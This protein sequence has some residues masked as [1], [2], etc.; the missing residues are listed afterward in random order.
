MGGANRAQ[1][2]EVGA[3]VSCPRLASSPFC[4]EEITDTPFTPFARDLLL[5]AKGVATETV[6][7]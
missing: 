3:D 1:C 5:R 4:A 2:D 6:P 7:H